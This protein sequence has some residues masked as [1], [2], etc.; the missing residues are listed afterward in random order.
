MRYLDN[1][2]DGSTPLIRDFSL[3]KGF[4]AWWNLQYRIIDEAFI[5]KF[6]NSSLNK[7]KLLK[8]Y[9]NMHLA[10]DKHIDRI[11]WKMVEESRDKMIENL[12][13]KEVNNG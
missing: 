12:I 8:Y 7:E 5:K 6:Q 13:K 9:I 4:W 1:Y 10:I 11:V 3:H 2:L